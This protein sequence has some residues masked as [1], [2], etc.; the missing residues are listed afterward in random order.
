MLTTEQIIEAIR[1]LPPI[2][3]E[4]IRREIWENADAKAA[5]EESVR[6]LMEVSGCAKVGKFLKPDLD[7]EWL[8]N[9]DEP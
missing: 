8:Y 7:R 6:I 5:I 4:R 3:K 2:E 9:E 1:L